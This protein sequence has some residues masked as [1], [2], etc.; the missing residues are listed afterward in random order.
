MTTPSLPP[1]LLLPIFKLATRCESTHDSYKERLRT[2]SSLS[3]VNQTFRELAQPLMAEKVY[4]STFEDATRRVKG[5]LKG[6]IK[7]WTDDNWYR[8]SYP[9]DCYAETTEWRIKGSYLNMDTIGSHQRCRTVDRH[10]P[11]PSLPQLEAWRPLPVDSTVSSQIECISHASNSASQKFLRI[12]RISRILTIELVYPVPFLYDLDIYWTITDWNYP[13]RVPIN[14]FFEPHVRLRLDCSP[15]AHRHQMRRILFLIETLIRH[16]D[17]L[18]ELYLDL[19]P[20][21]ESERPRIVGEFKER[22][23]KLEHQARSRGIAIIWEN[24]ENDWCKSLV[25]M[26]FWKRSRE[27][28]EKEE[29]REECVWHFGLSV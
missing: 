5:C 16:A 17:A 21:N 18:E 12:L 10:G 26:E 24:H 23:A 14:T 11:D 25:A 7:S 22:I 15:M 29:A 2:L 20:R 28:K 13:P 6:K 9:P 3:L 27:K 1:E 4:L 19:W 8:P